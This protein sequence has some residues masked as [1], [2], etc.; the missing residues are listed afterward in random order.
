MALK[1]A[2]I[3][4]FNVNK[5]SIDRACEYFKKATENDGMSTSYCT[6]KAD[7]VKNVKVGGGSN[8]MSGVALTCLQFMGVDRKD[9]QVD[10]SAKKCV[11]VGVNGN[12]DFYMTYYQALGLF[13]TGVREKYWKEFNPLMKEAVLGSQVKVGK[14]EEN[15][16]SWN[17]EVDIHGK[18]WGRVGETALG[19]LIME[20]Y[21]R[22]K[23]IC[24]TSPH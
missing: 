3:G 9:V 10:G 23:E 17:P 6:D 15:R 22:Y 16:G 4:Y 19:C 7:G 24:E 5:K 18:N 21:Y 14:Y 2:K 13:Q 1:S 8:R 11:G 12:S 20:V